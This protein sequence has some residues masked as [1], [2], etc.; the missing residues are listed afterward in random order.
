MPGNDGRG[1]SGQRG[2]AP[3]AAN[4]RRGA[5]QGQG[6]GGGDPRNAQPA[7]ANGAMAEALRRA[8]LV[9]DKS[10]GTGKQDRRSNRP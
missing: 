8:G 9:N 7:P 2:G 5:G 1:G 6:R 10:N 4:D 3:G